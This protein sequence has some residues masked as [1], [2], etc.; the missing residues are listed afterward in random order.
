[1]LTSSNKK[2]QKN[3]NNKFIIDRD[4]DFGALSFSFQNDAQ[5]DK[6]NILKNLYSNFLKNK[7]KNKDKIEDDLFHKLN[8]NKIKEKNG[9][10]KQE[11]K[12]SNF[13]KNSEDNYFYSNKSDIDIIDD[14]GFFKNYKMSVTPSMENLNKYQESEKNIMYLDENEEEKKNPIRKNEN[15][16]NEDD[17]SV[18]KSYNMVGVMCLGD[19][20]KNKNKKREN[21]LDILNNNLKRNN[22][23]KKESNDDNDYEY[24]L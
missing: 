5:N 10:H 9:I 13:S 22:I 12:K 8:K 2:I 20:N 7:K 14:V 1:M 24:L 3:D 4:L 16:G 11:R 21:D 19:K 23:Q 15:N 18:N 17:W 6:S